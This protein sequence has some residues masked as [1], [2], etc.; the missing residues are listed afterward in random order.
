MKILALLPTL[1]LVFR[2]RCERIGEKSD[3]S[4]SF[5]KNVTENLIFSRSGNKFLLTQFS[6]L[7]FPEWKERRQSTPSCWLCLCLFTI[8][9]GQVRERE[10][11]SSSRKRVPAREVQFEFTLCSISSSCGC[12]TQLVN[13]ATYY[14]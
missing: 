5:T 12:I 6:S 8:N 9:H 2:R 11:N 13:V 4:R 10:R 14:L 1:I 3:W 7:S